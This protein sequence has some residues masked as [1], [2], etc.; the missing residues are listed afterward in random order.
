VGCNEG[1]N[2]KAQRKDEKS[3]SRREMVDGEAE[4]VAESSDLAPERA[5]SKRSG[6]GRGWLDCFAGWTRRVLR[7]LR[8]E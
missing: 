2:E 6:F 8:G 3:R 5:S 1:E 7:D 4:T